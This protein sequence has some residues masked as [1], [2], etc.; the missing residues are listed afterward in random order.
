MDWYYMDGDRKIGPINDEAFHSL[1]SAS[2]ITA[3]TPVWRQG[4]SEWHK[5][6]DSK[7]NTPPPFKKTITQPRRG[8]THVP[9][10]E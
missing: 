8:S 2:V 10:P 7:V 9:S 6:G 3:E 4:W 5:S 1:L